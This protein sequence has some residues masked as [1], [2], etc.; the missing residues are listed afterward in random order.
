MTTIDKTQAQALA[1]LKAQ[2][3]NHARRYEGNRLQL[4]DDLLTLSNTANGLYLIHD[5]T[6][7]A[8]KQ[9]APNPHA[10]L[11]RQLGAKG[12]KQMDSPKYTAGYAKYASLIATI[13]KDLRPMSHYEPHHNPFA[14]HDTPRGNPPYEEM[15]EIATTLERVFERYDD[16]AEAMYYMLDAARRSAAD[17]AAPAVRM[18]KSV[19]DN[20]LILTDYTMETPQAIDLLVNAARQYPDMR[21]AGPSSPPDDLAW[22]IRHTAPIC[23]PA[24]LAAV[25]IDAIDHQ[26]AIDPHADLE[27][28]VAKL[29]QPPHQD[30]EPLPG[31]ADE[32]PDAY[33]E[34]YGDKLPFQ[35]QP[36]RPFNGRH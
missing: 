30:P 21:K 33:D 6:E 17:Q 32:D 3:E 13:G 27:I 5:L 11:A 31:D 20:L 16:A 26:L 25:V 7:R 28:T 22:L 4:L 2:I 34:R 1:D 36:R 29:G 18:L 35:P 23:P 14:R 19:L 15:V 9:K 8:E 10:V 24:K 12:K